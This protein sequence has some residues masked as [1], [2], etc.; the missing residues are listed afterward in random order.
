MTELPHQSSWMSEICSAKNMTMALMA[1]AHEKAADVTKL[2]CNTKITVSTLLLAKSRSMDGKG[3]AYLSPK[4]QIPLLQIQPRKRRHRHSRPDIS[5]V[6]RRP[7]NG[8]AHHD[9]R[10]SI[11]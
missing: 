3:K 2:Y 4:P 11:P 8:A 10:M 9:D 7:G 5:Q 6:V 1:M